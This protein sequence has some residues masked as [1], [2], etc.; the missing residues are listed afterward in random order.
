M[1]L[2]SGQEQWQNNNEE[3]RIYL[4]TDGLKSKQTAKVY[5]STFK[6]FIKYLQNIDLKVLLDFRPDIIESKV[7]SY[8]EYLRDTRKLSFWTIQVHY[9]AIHHWFDIND[10]VLNSRKIKKFL[11]SDESYRD[12]RP[13][14][15]EEISRILDKC[16]IRQRVIILLFAFTGMRVGAL[17]GLRIGDIKK[18]EEHNLYLI[19][20]YNNSRK[21]RYYTFCTPECAQAIDDYLAYRKRLGEEIKET[22][23][24]IR[25]K[26]S[27]D[28]PSTCI[29]T[30][31]HTLTMGKGKILN[32]EISDTI[33]YSKHHA[34]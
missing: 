9:S 1:V 33:R 29:H 27:V 3:R 32:I 28:N 2:G 34:I 24:L 16:D 6:G 26:I 7:I 11:P 8:L 15:V 23:P 13:Y 22:N 10:V 14:S 20:V 25:N 21:D 4:V 12:D 18:F 19:W 5:R 17:P 31:I 30:Y